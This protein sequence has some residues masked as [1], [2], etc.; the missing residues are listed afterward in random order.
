MTWASYPLCPAPISI[1]IIVVCHHTR[2]MQCQGL[3]SGLSSSTGQALYQLSYMPSSCRLWLWGCSWVLGFYLYSPLSLL[4]KHKQL[5]SLQGPMLASNYYICF[6]G[7]QLSQACKSGQL[8]CLL[9]I[10]S[11]HLCI[12][13]SCNLLCRFGK[14]SDCHSVPFRMRNTIKLD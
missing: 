11:L 1:V 2:F 5:W 3:N 9:T 7:F 6:R 8:Q 14:C 13:V 10:Y 4:W 12:L